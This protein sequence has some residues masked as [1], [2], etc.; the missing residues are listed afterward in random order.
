MKPKYSMWLDYI[1]GA[2]V[3]AGLA[4]FLHH[5]V[6]YSATDIGGPAWHWALADHGLYGIIM[7]VSGVAALIWRHRPRKGR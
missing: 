3:S 1:S 2:I 4:M 7:L 6:Y 5:V